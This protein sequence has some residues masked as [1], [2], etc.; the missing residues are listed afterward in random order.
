LLEGGDGDDWLA[1]EDEL[2]TE[3]VS[4]LTGNDT[5]S[6]GAGA[7]TLLG[8]SGADLLTGGDGGDTLMG[9]VGN[10]TLD[11]G[12]GSDALLGGDGDDTLYLGSTD[13]A[14]GEG[15]SNTYR[16]GL[17]SS[18]GYIQL[19]NG[20]AGTDQI[21][22]DSGINNV[23]LHKVVR[24]PVTSADPP[25][26]LFI[27][28][29]VGQG[30]WV[31]EYFA[32]AAVGP[33]S[34]LELKFA[35]GT[36][37]TAPAI[38]AAALQ[39]AITEVD[40]RD[41]WR[42]W[43]RYAES[44]DNVLLGGNVDDAMLIGSG[45][46]WL[47]G[48]DKD[49]RLTGNDGNNIIF[50]A[51]GND[52][53]LGGMGNDLLQGGM[54]ADTAVGGNG[55][56]TI[57]GGDGN[58]YL[59]SEDINTVA[60]MTGDDYVSGG[61]GD[62]G[63]YGGNGN[64]TIDGG[65]GDDNLQGWGGVNTYLFGRGDGHDYV[66]E[67]GYATNGILQ[68]K[69][70]VA[71]TDVLINPDQNQ[72]GHVT[73]RI[74]GTDDSVLFSGAYAWDDPIGQWV[75]V[76]QVRFA[77]GTTW[78][79][80]DILHGLEH[81]TPGQD[82]LV[83]SANADV[84]RG[85]AGN[86]NIVGQLGDDLLYGGDGDDLLDGDRSGSGIA[87]GGN[88]TLDGGA[89]NDTLVG[90]GGN[91]VYLFGRG[92]GQDLIFYTPSIDKPGS[93]GTL[94]FKAGVNP[95]DVKL[96]LEFAD[97]GV[98]INGTSD[99]VTLNQF[100]V[101]ARS[102]FLG[103]VQQI[104]FADGTIWSRTQM[105]TEVFKGTAADDAIYGSELADT[106]G[107]L[108]GNDDL[109]GNDGNDRISGG[110]GNDVLEGGR[111]SDTLEGG[112][113][114]D[115]L[116][117][118]DEWSGVG[119][120]DRDSMSGGAGDDT[121][122]VDNSLDV[123]SEFANE[124]LDTVRATVNW[125]LGA[126]LENLE[127]G[128]VVGTGNALANRIDANGQD[129]T[130]TGGQGNDTVKGGGGNDTYIFNRGDGQDLV[131]NDDYL[132][133]TE[134]YQ[135]WAVTTDTLRFGTGIA[136][137]DIV[138]TRSGD[139][140]VVQIRGTT[141]QVTVAGHFSVPVTNDLGYV[142]VQQDRAIDQIAFSSGAVWNKAR[143]QAAVDAAALNRAPM[144]STVLPDQVAA[145]GA[146]FSYTVAA[147][148]FT[149]PDVGDTLTYSA[150]L[151]DGNALPAWLT[152]N[153]ATRTF[154]G[155]P[156]ALGTTSVKVLALDGGNLSASDVFDLVVSMQHL[157]LT[158]TTAA[159]VMAGGT[160]ND[161][162]SG[163]AGNDRLMGQQ[164]NDVLDGGSGADSLIGGSGN[165]TYLVDS[166]SD[167]VTE[168]S[169]EG[170]DLVQAAVT[171]TLSVNVENLNL[172]GTNAINATGNTLD[173]VLAGNGANNSLTG[174]AGNDTL[175][176]AAGSDTMLGG[177][178]DDT[179][180]V[181]VA[182]DVVT[183]LTSEGKDT[184]QSS[185]TWSLG[186][187]VENLTLT[188]TAAI[189]GTGNTLNN[190]LLGNAANNTLDGGLGNDTMAGGAGNDTY[191][192]NVATD[193]VSEL[194]NE[195]VDM[196]Q[197]AV[198]LTLS[199]NVENL[200]LTGTSAINGTG[201]TLDNVL[202]GNSANNTLTAG[203]GNDLLDGGAGNDTM[204]GGAGNDTYVVNVATDVVTELAN[205]GIDTVQSAVTLTLTST[206]LENL[207]LTGSGVI[208]G[209]GN[210][211]DNVLIGNSANNTL[212]GAAGNDTLDGGLGSDTLVGG[213]GND[214]YVVNVAPDVVTEN[215]SEGTDTV[216]SAVT[217]T[218]ATNLENL[219][220]TGSGVIN[221]TG[222]T[223]ANVLVGNAASNVLSG[224]AGADT[225]D[226]GAGSDT[227]NGAAG[228][229]I[230]AFARGYGID[231]VQDN[232]STAGVKDRIQFAAGIA[233]AD[234]AYRQVGNNLEA[235]INGSTDKIVVQDWYLGAQYHVE[236]FRFND[237]SILSD[238]QVQGLVSAMAA[239][240]AASATT[241]DA[242]SERRYAMP[243][244]LAVGTA[245]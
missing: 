156:T 177:A 59:I 122:Y 114:N 126:N 62:D 218:L 30:I 161:T 142:V 113:G 98:L 80:Q 12:A 71:P 238:S 68:F 221:G 241:V 57:E 137:T 192:V 201:N 127:L 112:S 196:V 6:G 72:N 32:S 219:S 93:S 123:I 11:G 38:A 166:I 184:V 198:T 111:G 237:G 132:S 84:M 37:W 230:Y 153:A 244:H 21:V 107:G 87:G 40:I 117:F 136:E 182:T 207:T 79:M 205:E 131:L 235:L 75:T 82:I 102:S 54:G 118:A 231:T 159:D 199:A 25:A 245:L 158:G 44:G 73:L 27:S 70:G 24:A 39:Q 140:L 105:L 63:I 100:T 29:G 214:T 146:A 229:D 157:T 155:A 195:G 170:V 47:Y 7:D 108:A 160:G 74:A 216:Q 41:R 183:E 104:R 215:A 202:T 162:L 200:T 96:V 211:L 51:A 119:T 208:N 225:L 14:R 151:A 48:N 144:L 78:S 217:W 141:D 213:S 240:G 164:G 154:S 77:D 185:V 97:V 228:A 109:W 22:F 83:G 138:A 227:L 3:S 43:L 4:T 8:G 129:N 92:D 212:T 91:N 18:N 15:G 94:Q 2:S 236:E 204:L 116:N 110:D 226:G 222:N 133:A 165:D 53:I 60:T 135:A 143:I 89:G 223:S 103:S 56:D 10:D 34:A 45:N 81:G 67:N 173:N 175:D 52:L 95:A 58:D 17:G 23:V 9:G 193:V 242:G 64:D 148:A 179:Y 167:S 28:F 134:P 128:G 36:V 203:A 233:Q 180:V 35:D 224:L 20:G 189:S 186:S 55:S 187:N 65:A 120:A 206:N 210:A 181:N 130:I 66:Q 31:L 106:I 85:E 145:Q 168:L 169:G 149:D 16:V 124:G 178:G 234:L 147:T 90:G 163:L 121:Y 190:V 5:L 191:V 220:L 101:G 42:G 26:D 86:D 125:T 194:A 176:G 115:T 1:G 152:F 33:S 19:K 99:R 76:Q 232:D 13:L 197:S 61:A 88:D 46:A 50:G 172:T 171:Y 69:A 150:T 49:N 139:D 209:T 188:S 243:V 174:L 239:F